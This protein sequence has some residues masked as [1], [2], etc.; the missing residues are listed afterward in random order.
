[1]AVFTNQKCEKYLNKDW[2]KY[3]MI[4]LSTITFPMDLQKKIELLGLFQDIDENIAFGTKGHIVIPCCQ[5]SLAS[6][7]LCIYRKLYMF[8]EGDEL[9]EF[10]YYKGQISYLDLNELNFGHYGDY[11]KEEII[12]YLEEYILE[13]TF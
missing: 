13:N 1:M 4:S 6:T 5:D 2:Y 11:T 12:E 8:Y 3:F 10:V 7:F 9:Y